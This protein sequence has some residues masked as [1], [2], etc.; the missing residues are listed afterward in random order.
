M[1]LLEPADFLSLSTQGHQII[2]TRPQAVFCD[3]FYAGS[4]SIPHDE[5]FINT[6]QELIEDGQHVL[7]VA[8]EADIAPLAKKIKAAGLAHVQGYLKGSF[9]PTSVGNKFLD[10]IITIDPEE[11]HIDYRFDEFYLIDVRTAEAFAKEHIEY[12]ENLELTDLE[13][14][15]I[16]LDAAN[17]YYVYAD[18]S[19]EAI[20]AGSLFKRAGFDLVKV[21]ADSFE[22]IKATEIPLLVDNKK[23]TTS[24]KFSKN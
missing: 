24:T 19:R 9:D 18:N 23:K 6:F 13:A 10:M 22:N 7:I 16:D 3:G 5:D 17:S 15:L 11:F 21:V 4:I 8:D 1:N 12:A 2:D 14:L 20:I